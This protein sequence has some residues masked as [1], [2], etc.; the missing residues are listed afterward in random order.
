MSNIFL[1]RHTALFYIYHMNHTPS[2]QN[3]G[4]F[5]SQAEPSVTARNTELSVA[6]E[7]EDIELCFDREEYTYDVQEESE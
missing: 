6:V 2:G 7:R 1:D 5:Q 3:D 4:S